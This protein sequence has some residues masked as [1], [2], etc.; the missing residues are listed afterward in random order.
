MNLFLR[1]V[2]VCAVSYIAFLGIMY[3][4]QRKLIYLP[5]KVRPSLK[6]FKEVYTEFQTQTKDKLTLT[7]WSAK[8]GAPY[9]F[10]FHGNAGNIEDRA[11]K[12]K[13]LTDQGHSVFLVS[14]RGY[15][16]N[17][18]RPTELNLIDDSGRA[19][20]W[21]LEKE[22]VSLKEVVFFGESLGSGVAVALAAQ[23]PVGGL[24]FDGAYSSVRD[25]AQSVYPFI[26]VRFLL[27]DTWDSLSRIGKVR[28]PAFFIHSKKDTVLPFRFAE[29]LFQAANNPKKHLWLEHSDHNDNLETE[30]VKKSI[31]DF[32]QSLSRP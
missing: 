1:T 5:S 20:Q 19:L 31:L 17:P 23:Y 10:V 28:S 26:P 9:I 27:K 22:K 25:V 21:F 13:F 16:G 3:V 11:Y 18:G 24:I 6:N 8:R 32:L 12:F 29:K 7:H 15:G 4:L 14:Y 30:A 2:K